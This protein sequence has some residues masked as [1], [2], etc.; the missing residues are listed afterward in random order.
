VKLSLDDDTGRASDDFQEPK[1]KFR[2]EPLES[3]TDLL[4]IGAGPYGLA[5]ASHAQD[6]GVDHVVVG[7]P[8][9]FWKANMPQGMYLRSASDWPLD[10]AGVHTIE[11]FL[12]T[13]SLTPADVE[14]LSLQFYLRYARWF[15]EQ[16]RIEALPV[17]VR[18]L[19]YVKDADHRFRAT[20]EDGRI[21]LA[22]HVVIAV[23]FKYFKH[24]PTELTERLPVGRYSHTCDLVDF[25]GLR[26]KRCL[27]LGG[28][29]SAFEWTAL[30]NEAGVTAV[31]VSYRHDSPVF[32]AADWSWVNPLVDAMVGDP[33]WFRRLSQEDKDAV[34]H[35][36]WAEGRL[37]VEPGAIPGEGQ[38]PHHLGNAEWLS[39]SGRTFPD[40]HPE[41]LHDQHGG[42]AGFWAVLRLY[43][44]SADLGKVD[45]A[46]GRGPAMNRDGPLSETKR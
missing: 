9:E 33:G 26:G 15:Q 6:L 43:C 19:D 42:N 31:D 21:I 12:Q 27:V 20:L 14:P 36:L 18:G 38:H 10:P 2:I 24:L 5:I 39:R 3:K 40:Q 16:K 41:T 37:K 44:C 1:Q 35:R 4:I 23:G 34:S 25:R 7:R 30:L 45:R 46:G 13:Q 29:Q 22:H 11:K 8:M 32:K 28:R 17:L